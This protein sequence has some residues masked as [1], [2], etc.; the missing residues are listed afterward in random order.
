MWSASSNIVASALLCAITYT[1][2]EAISAPSGKVFQYSY[3]PGVVGAFATLG[4]A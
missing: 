3:S 2:P 1:S 4:N